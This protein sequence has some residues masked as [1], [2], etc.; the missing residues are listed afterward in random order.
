MGDLRAGTGGS[1]VAQP[2][3]KRVARHSAEQV[4]EQPYVGR[5]VAAPKSVQPTPDVAPVPETVALPKPGRRRAEPAAAPPSLPPSF[6]AEAPA[7]G[8]RAMRVDV[9][10]FAMSPAVVAPDEPAPVVLVPDPVSPDPVSPDPVTPD[11]VN[12]AP[13]APVGLAPTPPAPVEVVPADPAPAKTATLVVEPLIEVLVPPEP[14][15]PQTVAALLELPEV[16]PTPEPPVASAPALEDKP[17]ARQPITHEPQP[18]LRV[19]PRRA[20]LGN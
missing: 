17:V 10:P 8:R 20:V 18:Q 13:V 5:R 19:P 15:G 11:P 6:F 16:G 12:P 7:A 2:T 9:I 4:S 1:R 3:G 14:V